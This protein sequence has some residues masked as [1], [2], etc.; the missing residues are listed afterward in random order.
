MVKQITESGR[1]VAQLKMD[2]DKPPIFDEED[3]QRPRVHQETP[4][5][6]PHAGSKTTSYSEG[7][8]TNSPIP[9]M[10]FPKFDGTNPRIWID[11][12]VNYF[13]TYNIPKVLWVTASMVA[14]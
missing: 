9:K 8:K 13:T 2:R 5:N 7:N 11:K 14:F 6:N 12:A 1:A 4:C 10:P 3:F